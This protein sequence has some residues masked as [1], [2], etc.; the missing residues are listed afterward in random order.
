MVWANS[1]SLSNTFDGRQLSL[2]REGTLSDEVKLSLDV[3]NGNEPDRG[4][5]LQTGTTNAISSLVLSSIERS[6][7]SHRLDGSTLM[8]SSEPSASISLF[9]DRVRSGVKGGDSLDMYETLLFIETIGCSELLLS[10][11]VRKS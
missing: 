7:S 8:E 4:G 1:N 5:G 9:P 3:A 6:N 11:L 2:N 10:G